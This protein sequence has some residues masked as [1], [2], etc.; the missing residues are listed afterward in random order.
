MA[1]VRKERPSWQAGKYNGIGGHIEEG[2]TPRQA[3]VREFEEE[4]GACVPMAEWLPFCVLGGQDYRVHFFYTG[5]LRE[6]GKLR[7]IT[8][9][10]IHIL[11]V[12]SILFSN[13][14]QNLPWL[15]E[16]AKENHNNEHKYS[17]YEEHDEGD[18]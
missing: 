2:E 17:V 18:F 9:E 16:M 6:V 15:I 5:S 1:V 3:M 13:S 4:T 8:D 7:T 14:I 12:S 10:Q 11:P